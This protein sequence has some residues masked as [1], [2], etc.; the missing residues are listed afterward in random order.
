MR[1]IIL[2][3]HPIVKCRQRESPQIGNQS[4]SCRYRFLSG[5][6][7]K[8]TRHIG[9]ALWSILQDGAAVVNLSEVARRSGYS[10]PTI[11]RALA[12]FQRHG[13]VRQIEP[14]RTGKRRPGIYTLN[15]AYLE[16]VRESATVEEK[17]LCGVSVNPSTTPQEDQ[18]INQPRPTTGSVLQLNDNDQRL[19]R[20]AWLARA[21]V[22]RPPT[23]QEKRKL[24]F[25]VRL[26]IPPIVADPLLD[27][28]WQR[29]KAPLRLWRDVIGAI[30]G[31][32]SVSDASEK[33]VLWCIRHGLKRLQ[34]DGDRKAFLDALKGEPLKARLE[35]TERRLRGLR[36]WWIAQGENCVGEILSWCV[37]MRR[38]LKKELEAIE[39]KLDRLLCEKGEQRARAK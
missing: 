32:V 6:H 5:A 26:M 37:E 4:A 3:I 30:W 33:D 18:K 7:R 11:Y 22:D 12:F 2:C 21:D 20:T 17:S 34:Q 15:P 19:K 24:S 8:S 29:S 28:L 1:T 25:E 16:E 35:R 10:R 38:E 39:V 14:R 27:A 13:K 23:E 31:G 36:A 9:E